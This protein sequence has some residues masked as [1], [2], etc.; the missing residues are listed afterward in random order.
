MIKYFSQ[1]QNQG[2]MMGMNWP[3]ATLPKLSNI[4]VQHGSAVHNCWTRTSSVQF[5]LLSFNLYYQSNKYS[6]KHT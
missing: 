1:H 5:K 2:P 6:W 4:R 3:H